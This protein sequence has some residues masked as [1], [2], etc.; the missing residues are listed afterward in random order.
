[1]SGEPCVFRFFLSRCFF[2]YPPDSFLYRKILL[3]VC[4]ALT[5]A[6][7]GAQPAG[8][9][10]IETV[11]GVG[12]VR[13]G[14]AAVAAWIR[15]PYGVAADGAGNLFIAD[16]GNHRIRKVDPAGVIATVAG[17]GEAGFGGDG[18]AATEA[19]LVLDFIN[20]GTFDRME[21]WP[22]EQRLFS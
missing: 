22:R 14:G 12:D 2:L 16:T 11:A 8:A 1:M 3:V 7:A 10:V 18:G 5:A 19:Q 15:S 21:A 17:T 6:V 4:A 9:G 20:K 13:D